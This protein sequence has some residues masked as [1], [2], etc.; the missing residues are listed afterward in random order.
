MRRESRNPS[1]RVAPR[2]VAWGLTAL[3]ALG[4]APAAAFAG[5]AGEVGVVRVGRF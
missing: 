4:A 2:V 5:E 1:G 3:L